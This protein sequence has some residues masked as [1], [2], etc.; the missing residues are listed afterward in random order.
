MQ[1][2][3]LILDGQGYRRT[4]GDSKSGGSALDYFKQNVIGLA[5]ELKLKQ[6]RL[7]AIDEAVEKLAGIYAEMN[8]I[9]DK[10]LPDHKEADALMALIEKHPELTGNGDSAKAVESPYFPP[11]QDV[12]KREPVTPEERE[13]PENQMPHTAEEKFRRIAQLRADGKTAPTS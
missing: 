2:A 1:T 3:H 7:E 12:N 13:L 6:P 5:R 11:G 10:K 4:M 9:I 8:I